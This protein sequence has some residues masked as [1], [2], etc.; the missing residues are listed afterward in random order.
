MGAHPAAMQAAEMLDLGMNKGLVPEIL[1]LDGSAVWSAAMH[2]V[3]SNR[4]SLL[5]T[6]PRAQGCPEHGRFDWVG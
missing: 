3:I 2:I 6:M 4:R 1:D 5:L